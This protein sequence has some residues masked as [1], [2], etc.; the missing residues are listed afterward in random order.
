MINQLSNSK[1]LIPVM[2]FIIVSAT[3]MGFYISLK[4]SQQSQQSNPG[5][6]GLFWPQPKQINDFLTLDQT[7]APFDLSNMQG[8]WSFLF[9]GYTHC[10]D[11]CPITMAVMAD[12]YDVLEQENN[13]IQTVF[14]SV[15]PERDTTD[16]LSQYVNYFNTD[17]I[18]LGGTLD[19][20]DSLTRQIGVPYF[21]NKEEGVENYLVDHSASIFLIDPKGRMVARFSAPHQKAPIIEKFT[22][23]KTFIN[24]QS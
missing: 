8:K 6:P 1:L 14:V 24:A 12:I 7:G 22:K 10:P 16:K 4:Q 2:A 9:F 20:I 21:H 3:A 15:D 11:I 23:I 13:N 17:F 18:G 5:I 19:M